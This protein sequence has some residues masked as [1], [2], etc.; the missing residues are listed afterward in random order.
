M[1]EEIKKRKLLY[2]TNYDKFKFIPGNRP[3]DKKH[4]SEIIDRISRIGWYCDPIIVNDNNEIIDGQHRFEA[5][6]SLGL[7]IEYAIEGDIS[8]EEARELN[9]SSKSWKTQ[10]YIDSYA[11][12]GNVNYSN[13]VLLQKKYPNIPMTAIY[14]IVAGKI[15]TGGT[16]VLRN[17]SLQ[18]PMDKLETYY[19]ALDFV[20][21][22]MNAIKRIEGRTATIASTIAWV[23]TNTDADL[24]RYGKMIDREVFPPVSD[25]APH[26]FLESLSSSYNKNLRKDAHIK[27]HA[28]YELSK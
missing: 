7:P 25:C 23:V 24:A 14:G 2:S 6:R 15:Q 22:H 1:N 9:S 4:V 28:L 26:R 5:L 20:S 27:F 3:I 16:S 18:C 8:L 17:G 11:A 10:N 13:F 12:D 19:K 21:D